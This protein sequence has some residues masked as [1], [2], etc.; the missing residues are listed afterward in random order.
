MS[1]NGLYENQ[2]DH[3]MVNQKWRRSL[4]HVRAKR[5][6]DVGSDHH[7]LKAELKLK[8]RRN[9]PQT[10]LR[11]KR[12]NLHLLKDSKIRNDFTVEARNRF[13]MLDNQYE[14]DA[15][16][17]IEGQ[18]CHIKETYQAASESVLGIKR[19]KQKEWINPQTLGYVKQR[20]VLKSRIRQ[21]RSERQK[22]RLRIE[23]AE[24]NKMV[25]KSVRSD[26]R[27][28]LE[29][30][31]KAD[32]LQHQRMKSEQFTRSLSRFAEGNDTITPLLR[33]SRV[34]C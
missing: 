29:D 22:G 9:D 3:V 6:V 13:Q 31:A 20:R 25:K 5:G 27:Q 2:I 28:F 4:F 26:K 19:R 18:W 10:S 16:A 7:L 32:E 34:Q 12:Y 21:T 24:L 33:T 30:M 11:Q 8:L 23:Y 1:P 14:I 15:E 17:S